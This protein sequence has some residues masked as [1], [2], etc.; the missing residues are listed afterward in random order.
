MEGWRI[1]L[2]FCIRLA[3]SAGVLWLVHRQMGM[4][5]TLLA[6]PLAGVLMA[7]PIILGAENWL[8]W[9]K[10]QPFEQ[11]QG[12]YYEFAGT[13]IRIYV[14]G[15]KLWFA[16]A[17]VLNVL[18]QK[19]TLMLGSTYDVH[20]YD[21]IPDTRLHGFSEEGIEKLLRASEHHEAR[22]MLIW[23]QREVVKQHRRKLELAGRA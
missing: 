7:K 10:Q 17:D 6:M 16:D 3:I 21:L 23:V 11:W 13:Q 22:R 19:P 4:I 1:I 9:A 5:P 20:E 15:K 8:D 2:M 14:V 12:N 18:G